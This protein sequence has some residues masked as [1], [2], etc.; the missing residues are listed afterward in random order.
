MLEA[1]VA[2]SNT[3]IL[4]RVAGLGLGTA[5]RLLVF[6]HMLALLMHVM[7]LSAKTVLVRGVVLTQSV[8]TGQPSTLGVLARLILARRRRLTTTTIAII[9]TLDD[10]FAGLLAFGTF[11]GVFCLVGAEG[12]FP[13]EPLVGGGSKATIEAGLDGT[14]DDLLDIKLGD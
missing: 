6:A 8:M 2:V 14:L 11:G 12:T 7:V 5:R 9:I 4:A 3:I 10:G 13:E 1:K